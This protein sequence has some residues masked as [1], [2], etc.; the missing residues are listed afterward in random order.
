[1]F[2]ASGT[3]QTMIVCPELKQQ[4]AQD[5]K[6]TLSDSVAPCL[7]QRPC[8]LSRDRRRQL[9]TQCFIVFWLLFLDCFSGALVSQLWCFGRYVFWI[10][11]CLWDRLLLAVVVPHSA[12]SP[13]RGCRGC[14]WSTPEV[15]DFFLYTVSCGRLT[16][17]KQGLK[18]LCWRCKLG[19]TGRKQERLK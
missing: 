14:S 9:S 8:R 2:W 10:Y 11:E 19:Q 6:Y 5:R 15:G 17:S 18:P 16:V 4:Q 12:A 1:M 3:L 13:W 7:P